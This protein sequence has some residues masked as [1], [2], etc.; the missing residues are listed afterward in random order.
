LGTLLVPVALFLAGC[1][2][3]EQGEAVRSY[4]VGI[5]A[6][7]DGSLSVEETIDYEFADEERHGILRL[8]PY[9][10]PYQQTRDRLYPISDVAVRSPTGAPADTEVLDE[11]GVTTIQ[12]GDPDEEVSG[13]HTY[14]LT[15]RVAAV[16]DGDRVAWNAVGTGW[17]VPIDRVDVR[18][19]GPPGAVPVAG[20]C[21]VGGEGDRTSCAASVR[22]DGALRAT[23]Q[24]L[25][26]GE[27][28]TVSADF[29][30]GTFAGAEP[31][32][33]D[34]FS[35]ARAF[36][37]T[38]VT[39]GLAVGGLLAL[40]LPAVARAR[41]GRDSG[42]G[43]GS[44]PQLT[45]PQDALPGQLGTL[46]DGHA[47]RH[48][49]TATLLD[50]AVRGFLRVEELDGPGDERADGDLPTDWRLVRTSATVHGL[51]PYEAELLD[52]VFTDG[53]RIALSD[54]RDGFAAIQGRVCAAMYRDVV[55]LGWFAADPAATR[56]RWYGIGAGVLAAG[57]VLTVVLAV[58]STW[59]LAGTGVVLAGLVVLGLAARMPQRTDTGAQVRSR[60]VA[61]REH[62][63]ATGPGHGAV[64]RGR[65][66]DLAV[67]YLPHA[68]ALGVGGDWASAS[69]AWDPDRAPDWY[70]PAHPGSA[71]GVWPA[72]FAFSSP[73]NPA[74]APP[75][76]AGGAGATSVGGAAGGGGGG[77]W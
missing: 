37:L 60:A 21:V 17:E 50:L 19:A 24:G 5:V 23:A 71:A 53:D 65:T 42:G 75:A 66:T 2:G 46:V 25:G 57:V 12:V 51:R 32:L 77:S 38:P 39:G 4:Q 73:D 47:Q 31:V 20:A 63:A 14:V 74:L 59:A 41:R 40:T 18:L 43:P 6:G 28:V 34:T 10:V 11:D 45:P 15:Y 67:R 72:V 61:F 56:R 35:P 1:S 62:L 8:V 64:D 36:S 30:A 22:A 44:T 69:Q 33:D 49:V 48:E 16:A 58:T 9:R 26:P 7:A 27:G 76:A 3:D 52:A 70:R 55:D 54:L 29:P 68:V 13:R